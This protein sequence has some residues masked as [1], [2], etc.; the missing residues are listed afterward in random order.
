MQTCGY[1]CA[2]IG[3][4]SVF[5]ADSQE[6]TREGLRLLLM[7][8]KDGVI[9]LDAEFTKHSTNKLIAL[10]QF[11]VTPFPS[12][13]FPIKTSM[14]HPGN[15]PGVCLFDPNHTAA[16]VPTCDA[17]AT[18]NTP[19]LKI[20]PAFPSTAN[21]AAGGSVLANNAY[22]AGSSATGDTVNISLPHT[23]PG[24]KLENHASASSSGE[25]FVLIVR[26]SKMGFLLP[27]AL[28]QL[29]QDPTRAFVTMNWKAG[30]GPSLQRTLQLHCEVPEMLGPERS[31][32]R[33][34]DLETMTRTGITRWGSALFG[35]AWAKPT[36]NSRCDWMVSCDQGLSRDS[37]FG[38]YL[39]T[40]L[41][42][43]TKVFAV[44]M[45]V[46]MP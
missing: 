1:V 17:A 28:L 43:A 27:P 15:N 26:L 6:S 42:L 31:V 33:R 18:R 37:G 4:A 3:A 32:Q 23:T 12:T 5:V 40:L 14:S 16:H 20:V 34:F 2:Q 10:L 29:L 19:L 7:Q 24:H 8:C 44:V 46:P 25:P 21:T 38:R 13:S 41:A 11:A 45:T 30:D 39:S 35:A 36:P 9:G 22:D